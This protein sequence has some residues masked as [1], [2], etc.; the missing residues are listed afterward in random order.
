M[1]LG[2]RE[3]LF[4]SLGVGVI[5]L[6]LLGHFMIFPFFDKREAMKRGIEAKRIGL[7]EIRMLKA[8]YDSYRK[9]AEG[10]QRRLKRREKGFTLFSFLE[11]AAGKAKVKDHIK[12]MKPSDSQVNG[13]LKE[14][15]VEMKL[16]RIYLRPLVDYLYLVESW[17]HLVSI[18]RLSIKDSQ[19]GAGYLDA[20][21][22]VVTIV[23]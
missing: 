8:E 22:Q 5:A 1:K 3:K 16:D 13:G 4:V 18:K 19:G 6:F 7:K 10:I 21:V 2:K 23:D 14:S 12:Y 9:G 17:E 20:V 11:Q 15:M